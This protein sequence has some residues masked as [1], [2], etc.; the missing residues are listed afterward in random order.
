MAVIT[1]KYDSFKRRQ[2]RVC[3]FLAARVSRSV[4]RD[5]MS[6]SDDVTT[7]TSAR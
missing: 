6:A 7:V 4:S 1:Q 5:S 3:S 2:Q